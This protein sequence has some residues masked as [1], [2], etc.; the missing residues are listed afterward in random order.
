MPIPHLRRSYGNLNHGNLRPPHPIFTKDTGKKVLLAALA[1]AVLC[2]LVGT[3]AVV[4]VSRD[5]PDPNRLSDRQVAQST[6]IYDRTGEHLL[7]EVFQNQKRTLVEMNQISPWI[8]KAVVAMEDKKF[9]EHKGVRLI[10]IARA[11]FN[12]LI[13]RET[14]SGGGSTLT[15]QFIKNTIVGNKRSVFR[16]IKEAVLAI[17]LEKKYSKE[18]ILKMYLN[19]VPYGS[20]NYGVEA[21]AQNYFHKTAQEVT[22]PE[23]AAL[24][25]LIQAPSRYLNNAP[26]LRDRRDLI[27][28]LM[29]E[30]GMIAETEK[31][32][33][34]NTALRIYR[35]GNLM[36]APHFVMYVKQW[37]ADQY[38]ETTLDAGGLK[39]ITTIDYEKQTAAQKIVK[40]NGDK[41]AK[42]YNANNAALVA[43]D[44]K[45]SQILAM[46][47]SRD[48]NDEA[49]DG[50]FNVATLG[51][52]QPGSSFKPFVYLAAFELGY[53]PDTVLYD[54][55]TNFDMR[56]GGNYTPK[57]YDGKEHG[58]VTMRQALQGSLNIPGVKTL[59]LVGANEAM[60]FAKRF[61]YTT[62]NGDPG[63]SLVLGGS[64]VNL[65]EHTNGYATLANN[66]VYHQPV[67]ILKV[68]D[69]KG[70]KMF[71]WKE[72]EGQEAV[73]PELVATLDSVLTDDEARVFIFGRNSTLTLSDRKVAAKTGTTNDNKDAWTMGYTPSL[74]AG[75]WVG[76]TVPSPMKGGGNKLSGLIWNQFM[77]AALKNTP[78]ENFPAAPPNTTTK[79]V[80]R[81][82][83][84]GI[85]VRINQ[86]TGKIA[87]SSTPDNMVVER[88][89]M[90]PHDIL[91][92]VER[93]SPLGDA[94]LYPAD[95]PQ[96]EN[97]E[98]A[99]RDWVAREKQAG[100]EITLEDPPAEHDIFS[101]PSL[102]PLVSFIEPANGAVIENKQ[103]GV[104]VKA[105]A[106]RGVT[107]V[108]YQVDNKTIGVSKQFPFDFTFEA[109]KITSGE[110]ALRVS[111]SDDLGNTASAEIKF[112]YNGSV[113]APDFEWDDG[114]ALSLFKDSYPKEFKII[115]WRWDDIKEINIYLI[116][117]SAK[118]NIWNFNHQ[119]DLLTA[120]NKLSLTWKHYP[121]SGIYTL[122]G[123]L[124]DNSGNK[125]EKMMM[126]EVK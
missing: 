68:E 48:F 41:F 65:L 99:L 53:T 42:E 35:S 28:R 86:Y 59:Y 66:G 33:A 10:S 34:Q 82:S 49:I 32:E 29:F 98:T 108:A 95:D 115:P 72:T 9:Y 17:Q 80:L 39:V 36:N 38:G 94:P 126:V 84:G 102:L 14:G 22:L 91:H 21:A 89:Y 97:W 20:T 117:D 81:G 13:G 24:A 3:T 118:K 8:P 125:T 103:I 63:L 51:K 76:N 123:I 52:R 61:G 15:Q 73:K 23:A 5:L 1:G 67:S 57:N 116:K 69:N 4:Y 45:T 121:G 85:K 75:V 58:L 27:L 71:E 62:F 50:Q 112:I 83:I 100:Q 101:S 106:P 88:T 54:V 46:V 90:P 25:A 40:E 43:L 64:E 7:Y 19:E 114:E 93:H 77:R 31:K 78:A 11:A 37:L 111:A 12:N 87:A 107:Q 47:G 79:P 109:R 60:E 104:R 124:T 74:A 96:Y 119:E 6:K 70:N 113:D 2:F 120:D 122:K 18:D 44:P 30:Q 16:K 56:A 55:K 105:S 26:A 92:Y 110:H